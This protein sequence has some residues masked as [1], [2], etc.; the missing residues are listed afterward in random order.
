MLNRPVEIKICKFEQGPIVEKEKIFGDAQLEELERETKIRSRRRCRL[1]T[2]RGRNRRDCFLFSH[3]RKARHKELPSSLL[4][5]QGDEIMIWSASVISRS[6][7]AERAAQQ[8]PGF[9]VR[10]EQP[11]VT[12]SKV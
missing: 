2:A 9:A 3:G 8:V 12:S 10:K 11:S 4:W 1:C 6:R 5:M 7:L